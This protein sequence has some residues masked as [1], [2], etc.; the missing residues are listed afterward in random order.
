MLGSQ[1]RGSDLIGLVCGLA[2][3]MFQSSSGEPKTG[4]HWPVTCALS[5][6][7]RETQRCMASSAFSWYSMVP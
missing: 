1:S 3:E 6:M 2:S 7:G 4:N 5:G